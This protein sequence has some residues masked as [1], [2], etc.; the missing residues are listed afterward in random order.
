[1]IEGTLV[2]LRAPETGD[3]ERNTRW[4]NDRDVTRFLSVRYEISSTEKGWLRDLPSKPMSYDEV[5]F[6]IDTKD[7]VHIGNVNLS[8]VV[9]E[10]RAC[11]LG[12]TIGEKAY[13]SRGYG[14]DAVR[15]VLR[16]AFDEM[17]LNRVQ[18]GVLAYNHRAYAA[19]KRAGFV[20]EVRQRQARYAHGAYHDSIVMSVLREEWQP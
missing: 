5:F 16:F 2:N 8:G 6:A 3:L 11:T 15:T 13:W 12:I 18:L 19:Y 1:M 7:G 17:N 9:P 10:D 4:Y 20:E 14:T